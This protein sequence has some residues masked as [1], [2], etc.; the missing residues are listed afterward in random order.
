MNPNSQGHFIMN[1]PIINGPVINGPIMNGQMMGGNYV[2]PS[3]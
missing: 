1:G 2:V 3:G